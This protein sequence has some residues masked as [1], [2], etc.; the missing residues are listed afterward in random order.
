MVAGEVRNLA[1][2]PAEAVKDTVALIEE[3]AAKPLEA[4]AR[5]ED[6]IQSIEAIT[7]RSTEVRV[8]ADGVSAGSQEQAK[9]I[10]GIEADISFCSPTLAVDLMSS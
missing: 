8:M 5:L 6:A 4:R 2:R 3:F 1:Q 7:A 10:A 9:G